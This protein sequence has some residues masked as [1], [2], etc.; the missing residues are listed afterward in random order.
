MS[1]EDILSRIDEQKKS[2]EITSQLYRY[3]G[4]LQA[5]QFFSQRFSAEQILNFTYDFVTE[6]LIVDQIAVF[7][8][9][10]D[11]YI[12]IKSKGFSY[13]SYTL[14]FDENYNMIAKFHGHIMNAEDMERF[15]PSDLLKA[16]PSHLGIPLMIEDELYGFILANR[17]DKDSNFSQDDYIIA[18]ALMQL[19]NTSLSNYKSYQDLHNA[20][21]ELDEKIF[22]LFAINQS[23]KVLLS[24]LNLSNLYNLS[25]D[26]FSELTQSS[27]TTFFLYDEI[28]ESY[29]LRGMK[30]AF[31][32]SNKINLSLYLNPNA[33]INPAK[34]ILDMNN[35]ED[36]KYFNSI[37]MN[38]YDTIQ[39]L[40]PL[41]IVMVTKNTELLGFV[42]L[43]KNVAGKPYNKGIF[44]L[45]ESLSSS[46]YIALSNAKY[47]KQANEQKKLL[48][49][50]FDRLMSLNSLMKN[51]NSAKTIEQLAHLTLNTLEI[52][53]GMKTGLFALFNPKNNT[54]KVLSSINMENC[55]AEFPFADSLNCLLEGENFILNS[56]DQIPEFLP[57]ELSNSLSDASGAFLAPIN[58]ESIENE[59]LGI[60]GVFE[61]SEGILADSENVLTVN[62]IANHI[63]PVLYH[64]NQMKEQANLLCPNYENIFIKSLE[65]CIEEAEELFMDLE[66]IHIHNSKF[67]FTPIKLSDAASNKYKK[68]YRVTNSDLFIIDFDFNTVEELKSII[69]SEDEVEIALYKY[70]KDFKTVDDFMNCFAK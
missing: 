19:F 20:K 14:P 25:I 38:G 6:L 32:P 23:S 44:E 16:F 33:E 3:T 37:Y 68:I 9:Q 1:Y 17:M 51:I 15:L 45:I 41:Y 29:K 24:E 55:L 8:K 5:I 11:Q 18:E 56:K 2:Q 27:I 67:S 30:D 47:F 10:Y 62:T 42:T 53:F 34:T 54:F 13:T 7:S 4:L 70:K 43:G 36:I 52:S 57:E 12:L 60:I 63:S 21:A 69:S 40:K 48:Q 39:V 28:S 65:K 22:N 58:I 46:S 50:K 61:F 64:L 35:L 26:V 49:K 66:V 59:L 31:H